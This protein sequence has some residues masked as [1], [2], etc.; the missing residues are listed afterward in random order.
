MLREQEEHVGL[1]FAAVR[2]RLRQ[3]VHAEARGHRLSPQ[4]FWILIAIDEC[5]PVSLGALA[6]R[7]RMD[8]PTASRVVASLTRRR[9]VRM[10]EDPDDRRRLVIAA[11]PDGSDLTAR[12]RPV[13]RELREGLVA[14]FTP[15]ELAALRASLRRMLENLDR[16]EARRA[17]RPAR[18]AAGSRATAREE[19]P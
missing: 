18:V 6:A 2:R 17:R 8:P 1:L 5:G 16:Y 10:A 11:T 15:A 9:L 3:V 14:G 13:A 19:T 4:Q 7:L 12:L